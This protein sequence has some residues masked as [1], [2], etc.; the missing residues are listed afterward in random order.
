V[1]AT[2]TIRFVAAETESSGWQSSTLTT[3][4]LAAMLAKPDL[5][6][7]V[8]AQLKTAPGLAPAPRS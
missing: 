8:W 5:K 4:S 3:Y 2:A 6:K 7:A 1:T